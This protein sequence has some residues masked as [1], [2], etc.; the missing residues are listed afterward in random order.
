MGDN[1][2]NPAPVYTL[3]EVNQVLCIYVCVRACMYVRTYVSMY[4]RRVLLHT[5]VVLTAPSTNERTDGRLPRKR[6][7]SQLSSHHILIL[8]RYPPGPTPAGLPLTL[9]PGTAKITG[10]S[11]SLRR[12]SPLHGGRRGGCAHRACFQGRRSGSFAFAPVYKK[13]S[14]GTCTEFISFISNYRR[15]I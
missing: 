9:P 4:V 11:R 8:C 15:S 1:A 10:T 3:D 5:R 7:G 12:Y 13:P 14:I 6:N 2:K